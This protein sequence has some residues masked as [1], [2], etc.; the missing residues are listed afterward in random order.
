MDVNS[1]PLQVTLVKVYISAPSF[2]TSGAGELQALV[3]ETMPPRA[4]Q[5]P[6]MD[7]EVLGSTRSSRFCHPGGQGD[8]V[9]PRKPRW[10]TARRPIDRRSAHLAPVVRGRG[11][12]QA[13]RVGSSARPVGPRPPG[14]SRTDADVGSGGQPQPLGVVD[15]IGC[16]AWD[17]LLMDMTHPGPR[18]LDER[19]GSSV[20]IVGR[21][22]AQAPL[23]GAAA[24]LLCGCR[25]P[26]PTTWSPS[27]RHARW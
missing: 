22:Q 23:N 20:R 1:G 6:G 27:T 13:L 16:A 19:D 18:Q 25:W 7:A 2:F 4:P 17:A 5:R 21:R 8:Q 10:R 26:S 15:L 14:R 12:A 11:L 9:C 24:D 3:V